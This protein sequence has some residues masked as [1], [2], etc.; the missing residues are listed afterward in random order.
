MKLNEDLKQD[1]RRGKTMKNTAETPKKQVS[2]HSIAIRLKLLTIIVAIAGCA[3]FGVCAASLIRNKETVI[4][5]CLSLELVL[6][7]VGITALLC[8]AALW[9]FW[10]VST[11]IG[12]DN[13]FSIENYISFRIMSILFLV[14]A[15]VWILSLG[16]YVAG[17][18]RLE[19][20]VLF[21]AGELIF[22]WLGVAALT[23]TL[24]TLIDKARQI[25]EEN[26]LTI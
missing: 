20:A 1:H 16:V 2:Q 4:K 24:A 13:S 3:F 17:A 25:R 22:V 14:L 9:Q 19:S 10:K 15:A 18:G 21:K 26:D 12:R 7:L 23:G 5:Y 11:Q 6:V 8:Y